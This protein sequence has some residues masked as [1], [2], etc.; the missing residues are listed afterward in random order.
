MGRA[1]GVL[2]DEV[3]AAG[4]VGDRDYLAVG[5]H[6]GPH[7]VYESRPNGLV[8]EELIFAASRG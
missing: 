4:G 2:P 1:T 5:G 6:F 8:S 7:N 3:R